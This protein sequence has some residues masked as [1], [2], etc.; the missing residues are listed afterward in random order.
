MAI[1]KKYNGLKLKLSK[2]VLN[3]NLKKDQRISKLCSL[4]NATNIGITF[5]AKS[6]SQFAEINKFIKELNSRGIK[7]SAL[8]YIPEKKPKDFFLSEKT[9]NFFYD[10]ELDWLY[11]LKNVSAIEFQETKFDILIDIDSNAYYPMHMLLNKSRALFKVGKFNEKSPFDLMIDVKKSSDLK[12]YF[13][14]VI[15][16]LLKF[17]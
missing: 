10:K 13:D 16:Y 5:V 8:G 11:R 7:T 6:S 12:F 1:D 9:I 14:Q 2:W 4:K 15:H 3:R 17:N